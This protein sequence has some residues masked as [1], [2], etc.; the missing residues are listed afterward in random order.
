MRCENR[1]YLW[2]LFRRD[3]K[4]GVICGFVCGVNVLSVFVGINFGISVKI[5][6]FCKLNNCD[7]AAMRGFW[8]PCGC[9]R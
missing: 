9:E 2:F 6:Y 3:V 7:N 1:C 4:I 8:V 5:L